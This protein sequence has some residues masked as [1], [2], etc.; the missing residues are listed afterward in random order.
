[1][2]AAIGQSLP[3]AIGVLLSPM[4]IVAVVLMLV[5]DRAKSN[6]FAFLVGWFLGVLV[7]GGVILL[8]VGAATPSDDGPAEWI[9]IL[10]LVLGAAVLLLAVSQ[11]RHRPHEGEE[12]PTPTWMAA[13]DTFTPPKAFGLAFLLSAANPK[14][15]LLIAAGAAAI[16]SATSVRGDQAVAL[17]VF[18]LVASIGVATPVVVYLV[19]GERAA[20]LLDRLKT[21][22]VH[23]NSVIVAVLLLVIGAKMIGDG[24]AGL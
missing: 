3:V 23:N 8:L 22:M 24:I 5:S 9:S 21:W 1:V 12:P 17:L 6:G 13:I 14:N 4:P 19:M 18:A 20:A 11:F 10:K 16:A 15:L 2:G 7:A